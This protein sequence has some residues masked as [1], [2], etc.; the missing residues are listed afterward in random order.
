VNE[1][2]DTGWAR[3]PAVRIGAVV[4]IALAAAFAVWL[5]VRGNDD[6]SS[7]STTT[8]TTTTAEIGPVAASPAALR[9]LADEAGHPVYW[10]GP[11]PGRTYELTRTSSGRIF[12]RYLPPDVRVG[13]RTA[14]FTIVGSYPVE[15]AIDVLRDLSEQ[16]GER[17][18][19]VPGGGLAVYSTSS[20]SN[21]YLAYPGS[22][23]QIEVFDPSAARA[24]RLATSGRVV[25]VG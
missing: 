8:P 22:D 1:R 11:R 15:N 12:I 5:L 6:S 21:V 18:A 13:N 2:G 24:L 23:V 19:S 20:P 17:S 14:R 10:I 3:L 4:A 16:S 25:P 7:T 9:A